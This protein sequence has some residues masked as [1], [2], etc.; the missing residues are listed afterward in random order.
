MMM[1]ILE[2]KI[3]EIIFWISNIEKITIY[4]EFYASFQDENPYI[5]AKILV[6]YVEKI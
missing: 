2:F 3:L 6:K 1:L 4:F 5:S